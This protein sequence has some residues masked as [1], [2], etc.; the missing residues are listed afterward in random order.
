MKKKNNIFAIEPELFSIGTINLLETTQS[1]KTIDVEIMDT[2]GK[3]S[4]S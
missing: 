3:T 1:M 4:I 2:N